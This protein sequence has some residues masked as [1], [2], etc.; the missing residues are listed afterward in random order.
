MKRFFYFLLFS[1]LH[2]TL[3][4]IFRLSGFLFF[5][6][7]IF[8]S[9][10]AFSQVERANDYFQNYEYSKA[11]PLY[12]K[13]LKND[14][15]NLDA[16]QN[17]AHCYRFIGDYSKAEIF[18]AKALEI[19]GFDSKI[20][21][22]Y[23]KM[24][25]ANNKVDKAK[26]V[27]IVYASKNPKNKNAENEIEACDKV[28]LWAEQTPKRFELKLARDINSKLSDFSPANY[29]KGLV[30]VSE[31]NVDNIENS[32]YSLTG[33]P[34]LA[35][36]Q[37]EQSGED[38]FYKPKLFPSNINNDY[39]NG[40]IAFNGNFTEGFLTRVEMISK[41]KEYTNKPQLFI[42]KREKDKWIE[43]IAFEHNNEEYAL[44]HPT[45]SSDGKMLFFVS[46]MPGGIGGKDLY[47]S[48]Q[49]G[50]A[51]SKPEN[52]GPIVN[53]ESDEMFPYYSPDGTL[54][55]SSDGH[56]GYGGMDIFS[57]KFIGERWGTVKNL[58]EPI[59]S[60]TD[61]FGVMF[62]NDSIGFISSNRPGGKGSDDIYRFKI[63][64]DKEIHSSLTGIFLYSKLN[65]AADVYLKLLDEN[66]V[67]VQRVKTNKYG[68][69]FFEN[70]KI[71]QNYVVA[72]DEQDV[73]LSEEATIYITNEKNDKVAALIKS[74]KKFFKFRALAEEA[75][76]IM[77][78][79]KEEDV[80]VSTLNIFAQIYN[81][82][83]GD[84]P[85]GVEV[86][87][88]NDAGEI[89]YTTKADAK[90]NFSIKNLPP[91]QNYSFRLKNEALEAKIYILDNKNEVVEV[92]EKD[93]KGEFSFD[94]LAYDK[95]RVALLKAGDTGLKPI[96]LFGQI[97]DKLPG[98]VP[99]G[100]QVYAM[101]DEGEIIAVT[102]VD[103]K[104][105][106][107]FEKLPG[108]KAYS[109]KLRDNSLDAQILVMNDKKE[110]VA[111]IT[112]NEKGHFNFQP[113]SADTVSLV[114]KEA[115]DVKMVNFVG[116][117]FEK[118]PGDVPA[119]MEVYLVDDAGNIIATAN[120]DNKGNFVFKELPADK[121]YTLKIKD[122]KLDA[123]IILM[124]EENEVVET[125]KKDKKGNF[126]YEPLVADKS[127][128]LKTREEED[129]PPIKL[130][131]QIFQTLKGDAPK[132]MEVYAV[133]D[134]GEIIAIATI[135]EKGNFVFDK[136]PA[137]KNI[138]F[139]LKD[140]GSDAKIV[141]MDEKSNVVEMKLDEK[142]HFD[143]LSLKGD[144]GSLTSIT[145]VD[146]AAMIKM[147]A[148]E[149]KLG[150]DTSAVFATIYYGFNKAD[151]SKEELTAIIKE[152][153]AVAAILA[154]HSD[155]KVTLTA[156]TDSKGSEEYNQKLS[157]R[158]VKAAISY[159]MLEGI[160]RDRISGSGKGEFFPIAPN[161][162]PDGSDNP[163]G[164]AKNRRA[165]IR[166]RG[167]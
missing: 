32:A 7:I 144:K 100:M 36:Y 159:L 126:N 133:N 134:A 25:K 92:I 83:P 47:L 82:L 109:F 24:L 79:M 141:L 18:Y 68:E 161:E 138:S 31:R 116:K 85:A 49:E 91:D 1:A 73:N 156:F 150:F 103:E 160:K 76:N 66:N 149:K 58:K 40:P 167:K 14:N 115:G 93:K 70:L 140:S 151:L 42:L 135:D 105:N 50:N 162:N 165:E 102:T 122:D 121:N 17:L 146:D 128:K 80:A 59:N 125:M 55:F 10:T 130:K 62:S 157:E 142:G 44:A 56:M 99:P 3:S 23:G 67:E 127:I 163:V 21:L 154:T 153:D 60:P 33:R 19:Q 89:V 12:Q 97:Y 13:V 117:M 27:F 113:L 84:L 81:K 158:R 53:T 22:L 131:G 52:L 8:L 96:Q 39:H 111:T 106:F 34:F 139:R 48:R 30:F 104:G 26:E 6:G 119:G 94:K 78:F 132:G 155:L 98:D 2:N 108:D 51:W 137:D 110:V 45:L 72:F 46:D 64:Y 74:G 118:L 124:N 95:A 5:S 112:K 71:D 57:A 37:A 15:K 164:R 143:Y 88:L 28:K 120:I 63:I 129:A 20:P 123:Q 65:P 86:L 9:F 41:G 43:P 75:Y 38:T 114:S 90:G 35:I 136:L 107:S 69:F 148:A 87:I 77:P 145:T 16:I 101:N 4:N 166:I 54:Y 11:I 29:E 147:K 61:D 152:L